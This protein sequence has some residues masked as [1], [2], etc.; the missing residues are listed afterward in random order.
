M[1]VFVALCGMAHRKVP[2]SDELPMEFYV[3]FWS[4]LGEDLVCTLNSSFREGRLSRSQRRG[5]I[6][7]SFKKG[8]HLDIC[9]WC[10]ISLLNADY[11]LAVR[12]IAGRLLK[13]HIL[14]LSVIRL[15]VCQADLLVTM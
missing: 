4:L 13:L 9:N 6:S 1:R 2:G 7:L 11:K 14:S 10:P 12:T 15:V 3:K 8:D 5:I